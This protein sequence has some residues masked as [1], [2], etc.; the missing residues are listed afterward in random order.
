MNS[1]LI[2]SNYNIT[3]VLKADTFFYLKKTVSHSLYNVYTRRKT[4]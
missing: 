3:G 4:Y 1:K 2:A